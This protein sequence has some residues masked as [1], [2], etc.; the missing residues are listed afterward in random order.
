MIQPIKVIDIELS[1]P[2]P[3]PSG[4]D[5]YGSVQALVRWQSIPLGSVHQALDGYSSAAMFDTI[6]SQL[7]RPLLRQVI[8]NGLPTLATHSPRFRDWLQI[9]PPGSDGIEWPRVTVAICTRDRP[10][11]L[12]VCLEA[13]SRLDYP[14]LD[15]LVIDN[16]PSSQASEKLVTDHYPQ[17]RYVQEPRPG[18]SWARNR[19]I[20]E[21][22]GEL[23]AFTDD[24]VVVDPSWIRALA[25]V[26]VENSDVM[27]V[28]GL[29]VP[30]ELETEAQH[31]FEQRRGFG[32]GFV[33]KWIRADPT[34]QDTVVPDFR[35][36]ASFGTGANM[37]Y[38]REVFAEIGAFDPALGAGTL[39]QGAEDIEMFYRILQE[40][41]TLI[42]EPRALV[43]HRHR[44]DRRGLVKQIRNSGTAYFC[45]LTRAAHHYPQ[46]RPA[47][48]KL[49]LHL[50][51]HWNLRR[52]LIS[53]IRPSRLPAD[54][55]WAELQGSLDSWGRYAKAR[56]V[57]SQIEQQFGS[58]SS[59]PLP[60]PHPLSPLPSSHAQ[61]SLDLSQPLTPIQDITR[62][63]RIEIAVS[64]HGS[65]LGDI[66]LI[67]LHQPIS[68][69][70]LQAAIVDQL[71]IPLLTLDPSLDSSDPV[72]S[73]Q[74]LIAQHFAHPLLA[75]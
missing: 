55:V 71:T 30:L 3:D 73:A 22:Q 26:F 58:Q 18:L 41:H 67:T 2:L 10:H 20:L 24:D 36:T 47:L 39:T 53:W 38:R 6:L 7:E 4:W 75:A 40:G 68:I 64:Y 21:A 17:V 59:D 45:Y 33:S 46:D 52:L 9:A 70:R 54:L 8:L 72:G 74:A 50:L 29:V 61:I 63:S 48:V 31:L 32:R 65:W 51:V 11:D 35:S 57:V 16:A 5:G 13:L 15:L 42:Y 23:I 49:G 14:D 56:Q 27:A 44:R 66:S 37:A 25:Q 34:G 19:A 60:T 43:R 1:H 69:T 12:A 62:F 28:T